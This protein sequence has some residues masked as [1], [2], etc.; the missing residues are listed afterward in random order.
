[1]QE[2]RWAPAVILVDADYLD[3]VA[4]D[5]TVNFERMLG[6]RVPEGDLCHWID[7]VALDGGLRPGQNEV[8]VHF[9]HA[10]DSQA[11]KYFRPSRFDEDLNG[12]SFDDNLGRFS[13]FA[14]PV[15]EVVSMKEFFLQSMAMLADVKDV[16]QLMVVGDMDAYGAEVKD[17]C[18]Q[19]DGKDITLFSMEP[20]TGRGFG[21]EIL[22]YSLM[23]ALGIRADEL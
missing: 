17:I 8:Q 13:L 20:L 11:L 15:E 9:L 22:G 12:L 14:F 5:L 16:K 21:Q 4:F 19:T 18:R 7:C 1:M 6:R 2:T 23:A 10:K 3:R